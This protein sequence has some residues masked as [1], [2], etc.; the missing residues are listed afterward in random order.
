MLNFDQ[1]AATRFIK[2][3]APAATSLEPDAR[4]VAELGRRRLD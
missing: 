4:A 1:P 3:Q 2:S